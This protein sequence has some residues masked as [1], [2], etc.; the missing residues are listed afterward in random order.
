MFSNLTRHT[1]QTHFLPTTMKSM[2]AVFNIIHDAPEPTN[3]CFS[4]KIE[5]NQVHQC[6]FF[7]LSNSISLL[8]YR[9]WAFGENPSLPAAYAWSLAVLANQYDIFPVVP[10]EA[11][12]SGLY[13]NAMSSVSKIISDLSLLSFVTT[14]RGVPFLCLSND[15]A[16]AGPLIQQHSLWQC[17]EGPD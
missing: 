6:L 2:S 13:T 14:L 3:V 5:S 7:S 11:C 17:S 9:C 10:Q 16:R 1:R 12:P 15:T 4:A 8:V